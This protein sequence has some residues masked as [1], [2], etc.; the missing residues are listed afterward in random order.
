MHFY[1][2]GGTNDG[3]S[4]TTGTVE[5]EKVQENE[6][7]KI[8]RWPVMKTVEELLMNKNMKGTMNVEMAKR[9][10]K[11]GYEEDGGEK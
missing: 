2:D 5:D 7:M 9:K 6:M 4:W 8:G 11:G 10:G 3:F 1:T